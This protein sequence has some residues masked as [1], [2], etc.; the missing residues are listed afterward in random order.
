[1]MTTDAITA[2]SGG[3]S[4]G[5][6]GAVRLCGG[7]VG[8]V[9]L[10]CDDPEPRVPAP[11]RAGF[12]ATVYPVLLR[13]CGFPACHGDAR[14]PLFTPGP[15]RTRL[16]AEVA[17]LDPATPA[18]VDRAYDR[19]RAL[20]LREHDEPP[21]LLHKPTA[22]AAHRGR[23]ADGRNVYEDPAAPGLQALTAWAEGAAR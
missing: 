2:T 13:D 8:L 20:L 10:G 11:D 9:L 21:P 16:A 12:A 14:R 19:A 7:L 3:R 6:D 23:D 22:D 5:G 17:L 18:E 4:R 1:M 15:G